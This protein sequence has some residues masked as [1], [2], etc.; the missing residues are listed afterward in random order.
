MHPVPP[1]VDESAGDGRPG[2]IVSGVQEAGEQN[3]S[4]QADN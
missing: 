1:N 3:Q 2:L 4:S